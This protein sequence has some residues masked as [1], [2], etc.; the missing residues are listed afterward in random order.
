[1]L[2]AYKKCNTHI[3]I[4]HGILAHVKRK[5]SMDV[6]D[7]Y[8]PVCGRNIFISSKGSKRNCEGLEKNILL[9]MFGCSSEMKSSCREPLVFLSSQTDK[10][11]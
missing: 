8:A 9:K 1:M 6:W 4:I 11:N 5:W 2:F 10:L 3:F 7:V